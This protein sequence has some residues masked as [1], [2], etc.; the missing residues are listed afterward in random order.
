[1]FFE[2]EKKFSVRGDKCR[3]QK[4]VSEKFSKKKIKRKAN[5]ERTR[6]TN[7][8]VTHLVIGKKKTQKKIKMKEEIRQ[9]SWWWTSQLNVSL[10]PPLSQTQIMNFQKALSEGMESKYENHWYV[11][12]KFVIFFADPHYLHRPGPGTRVSVNS[13]RK[14]ESG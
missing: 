6:Q 1:V 2:R 13:R 7:L 14:W 4:K 12:G 9:A 10:I 8:F 11:D 3:R 5:G